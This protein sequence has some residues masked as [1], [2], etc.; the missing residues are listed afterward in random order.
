MSDEYPTLTQMKN[1]IVQ[2]YGKNSFEAQYAQYVFSKRN[3]EHAFHVFNSMLF[4]LV[5]R[6]YE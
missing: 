1:V 4:D 6:L 2:E 3:S 5:K